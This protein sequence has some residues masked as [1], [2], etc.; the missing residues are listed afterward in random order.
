MTHRK[1]LLSGVGKKWYFKVDCGQ[2]SFLALTGI[3]VVTQFRTGIVAKQRNVTSALKMAHIVMSTL[4]LYIHEPFSPSQLE[5]PVVSFI[6]VTF[7]C[8]FDVLKQMRRGK[9]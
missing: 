6:R 1:Q 5:T 2:C 3:I 9:R 7:S 4:C 8:S